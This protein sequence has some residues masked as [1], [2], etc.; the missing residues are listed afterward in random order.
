MKTVTVHV[1]VHSHLA[2]KSTFV[3]AFAS[4]FYIVSIRTLI[5]TQGMAAEPILCVC[6]LLLLLP[7]F[8]KTQ[9]QMLTLK[10]EWALKPC[11]WFFFSKLTFIAD[12]GERFLR[13]LF[14]DTD[15]L[16]IANVFLSGTLFKQP[17]SGRY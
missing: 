2:S 12:F 10:S 4:N 5:L 16:I 13:S 8:S 1:K 9:K 6:I 14:R 3:S 15:A 7:L 11:V 17:I